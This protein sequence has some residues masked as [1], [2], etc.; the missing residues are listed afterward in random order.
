MYGEE[1]VAFL[2]V[3]GTSIY[4]VSDK[5]QVSSYPTFIYVKPNTRGLKA[6]MFRGD[7]TYQ[8]MMQWMKRQLRDVKA[9][10]T[11][12]PEPSLQSENDEAEHPI[13]HEQ[14]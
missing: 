7:R 8:G 12:T 3:D 13:M 4:Q 5:Y 9:V 6:V 11:S 1:Q 10:S 14:F 2:K